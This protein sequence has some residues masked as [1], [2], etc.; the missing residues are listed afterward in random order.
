M[1]GGSG[2]RLYLDEPIKGL[3]GE[4][5]MLGVSLEVSHNAW[6]NALELLDGSSGGH[7]E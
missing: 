5:V 1:T 2:V 7:G 3:L 6:P 4:I